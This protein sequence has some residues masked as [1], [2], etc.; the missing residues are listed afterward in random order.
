MNP[1]MLHIG[2]PKDIRRLWNDSK[3][4]Q[5][6][7]RTEE[8]WSALRQTMGFFYSDLR[9]TGSA[10]D[11]GSGFKEISVF[12]LIFYSCEQIGHFLK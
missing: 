12:Y 11:T 9:R 4:F 8:M 10:S 2:L 3:S 6:L 5:M 1:E 7:M